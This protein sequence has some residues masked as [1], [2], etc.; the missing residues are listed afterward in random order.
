MPKSGKRGK[1]RRPGPREG[2]LVL[3]PDQLMTLVCLFC[4]SWFSSMKK[5]VSFQHP[6]LLPPH[7]HFLFFSS[8]PP[9]LP[10]S[11]LSF[12]LLSL[13][14]RNIGSSNSLQTLEESWKGFE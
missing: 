5:N 7:P 9:S 11:F 14:F 12:L 6:F 3:R 13:K 2:Q 4:A 10:P 8:L 1:S